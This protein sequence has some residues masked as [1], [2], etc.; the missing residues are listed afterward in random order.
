V[1]PTRSSRTFHI[2]LRL[3]LSLLALVLLAFA[4]AMGAEFVRWDDSV[5]LHHNPRLNPP[6]WRNVAFYWNDWRRGE[7]GLYVPLTYTVWSALA[8]AGRVDQ[9]D[10]AG[11]QL[12]PWVFHS[13]NVAL[14]AAAALVVLEL[15]ALLLR[16]RTPA[17]AWRRA[18]WIG[19]A[20]FAVHPLQVEPVAWASGTKDV[21][22]GLLSLVAIWV[23]VVYAMR[24]EF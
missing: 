8:W 1:R 19:A 5:T 2:V 24:A 14:H 4:P 12:N 13:A 6:S 20:V 21:L 17:R 9:P 3:R 10:P 23:Y 18:A 22:G 15:L 11:I 7:N 16:D